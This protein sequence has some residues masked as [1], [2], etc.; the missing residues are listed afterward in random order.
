MNILFLIGNGFDLSLGMKTAYADF[1]KYYNKIDSKS[2]SIKKL[3]TTISSDLTNWSDLELAIGEYTKN[4]KSLNEFEEVFED[5]G[6]RLAEYLRLL[7]D[8]FDFNN[9]DTK[10][11]LDYFSYPE[12]SLPK[13]DKDELIL[14]KNK[15]SHE[16][17]IVNIITF[18]YTETIESLIGDKIDNLKIGTHHRSSINLGGIEHIHGYINKRMV[19]GVND[20]TQIANTSFRKNQDILDAIVKKKCNLAHKHTIDKLCENQINQAQLICIFGSSIGETDNLWWDSIVKQLV[21]RDC[22]LIIFHKTD[23]LSLNRM[24]KNGRI[25]REQKSLFL[26]RGILTPNEKKI[27]EKNIYVGINTDMFLLR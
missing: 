5:I 13:G 27:A 6:D 24:Y 23:K 9:F 12:R 14:F 7:Y 17:W 21:I 25:E 18:N 11:L 3:K 22:K 15:W 26:K 4:I 16:N 2:K 20:V 1:Y 8:D 10:K 19:M